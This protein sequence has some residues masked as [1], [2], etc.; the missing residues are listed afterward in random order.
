L[1]E[2]FAHGPFLHLPELAMWQTEPKKLH[3]RIEGNAELKCM[4]PNLN[5]VVKLNSQG[6]GTFTV[7]LTPD[8]IKQKH[9]VEFEID[10]SYLPEVIRQIEVNLEKFPIRT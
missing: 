5:A 4:E 1:S 3:N 10:Q 6:T 9:Q 7:R 8:P 2:V